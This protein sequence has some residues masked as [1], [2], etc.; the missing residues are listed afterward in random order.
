MET[1]EEQGRI[2]DPEQHTC[3]QCGAKVDFAPGTGVLRCPYCGSESRIAQAERRIVEL[4]YR[5]FLEKAYGEKE[6][7]EAERVQCEKCGAETTMP[8]ESLAGS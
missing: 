6:S 5:A 1:P 3:R 2:A 7:H 4:D 8:P